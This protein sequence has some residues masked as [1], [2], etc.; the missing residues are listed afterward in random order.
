MT[1]ELCIKKQV[2][3]PTS[4]WYS[5]FAS[6]L[7]R[8]EKALIELPKNST[9]AG[10][11]DFNNYETKLYAISTDELPTFKTSMVKSETLKM[12]QSPKQPDHGEAAPATHGAA[13]QDHHPVGFPPAQDDDDPAEHRR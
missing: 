5:Y 1:R 10:E 8:K 11:F 13:R 2:L 4:V 12:L 6:H 9:E 7:A 3:L